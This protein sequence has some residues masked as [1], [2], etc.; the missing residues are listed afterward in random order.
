MRSRS[1][2]LRVPAV[3]LAGLLCA[4]LLQASLFAGQASDTASRVSAVLAMFP[5]TSGPARDKAAAEFL[6]LGEPGLLDACGRLSAAG[7][8]D[9]SLVRYALHGAAVY[10]ARS[11]AEAERQALSAVLVKALAAH[12]AVE[13][14]A[15]LL[16]QLQLAGRDE[17][18]PAIAA[19]L[20]DPSL[21]DPA[22]RALATIGGVAAEKALLEALAAASGEARLSAVQALGFM[23]SRAA[24]PALLAR[25]A[26]ADSVLR[27][28]ILTALAEIGDPAAQ[29]A[30]GTI[31]LAVSS[32][33]RLAAASLYLRFAERLID[34]GR[35]DEGLGILRAIASGYTGAGESQV[36][37]DALDRLTAVLGDAALPDLL[38]AAGSADPVYRA[39]ALALAEAR[40]GFDPASWMDRGG[41]FSA[42]AQADLVRLFGR[43]RD[44]EA[45]PFIKAGLESD[46]KA[47]RLAAVEAYARLRGAAAVDELLPFFA[48]DDE[49]QALVMRDAARGW[50][51]DAVLARLVPAI[52]SYPPAAQ[53]AVL[54]I[55]AERQLTASAPVILKLAVGSDE[56]VRAAALAALERT[57]GPG[58]IPA[59]L[60]L[61]QKAASPKEVVPLQ[62]ALAAACN[63]IAD[64]ERRADALLAA[65]KKAKDG[66]R[67]D[68]IRP[69]SRVGGGR[70]LLAVAAEIKGKVPASQAAALSVLSGWPDASALPELFRLAE[71]KDRKSRYLAIQGIAR[72]LGDA[73]APADRLGLWR[74]AL[75]LAVEDDEKNVLV[76]GLGALRGDEAL[77]Q[78][79]S[80]L[81]QAALQAKAAAAVVKIV[82]PA[83]GLPGLSGFD[84]GQAL[85][86]ALPY[87]ENAYDREQAEKYAWDLLLG[88]GFEAA[89]NGKNL[90]GWKGLVADPP[91]R[92]K[93]T[94]EELAKAQ[95]EA[96]ALMKA[97]WKAVDG[98][99][100]FDGRGHSLCT[101]ADY[102]DFEMFVDW[103][104]E[105]KGDSGIYLR[106]SPQVQIWDPAQWPE[107]S[108][109]LY[110]N[111]KNPKNPLVK[112]DR[113]IGEWN[114]FY[115]KMIGERVT[116]LLN[117]VLV[118]DDVLMENYWERD[119]PIYAAGQIELQSHST[120]LAF[121][122]IFIR[123]I[124]PG[125]T[126]LPAAAP[127]IGETP[128]EERAA[129][130]VSLFNGRDLSGWTGDREGYS[131]EDG[132]IAVKPDSGGNLYTEKDY[133][134]FV[135]RFEFKL[136]PGANNG[137]GIRTPPEGD[138]AYVGMEIQVLDDGAEVYKSLKPY[139]YHGSIYGVVPTRRGFQKP[140][141][142]W[143]SE[144]IRVQGRRV[145][146]RLNGVTIVDADIEKASTPQTVDGRDHPGLKR[147]SGR[148]SFCGHGSRVE[149]R[150]LRIKTLD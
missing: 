23:K 57:A 60:D 58:E 109:G 53:K 143:N 79:A 98:T 72:L 125:T 138:A 17:A 21:A 110:N 5:S 116:V 20:A 14:K 80:F 147:A 135:F 136:T 137:I 130:F 144:E 117:G 33:D 63:R 9:D 85:R 87:V 4:C 62:N 93:M 92:A 69:L 22:A 133:A 32:R 106:G 127:S 44:K 96:D 139:Q 149:F 38:E 132:V 2:I 118:V 91:A 34:N 74:K 12:P 10:A 105:S 124:I 112:A 54:E 95:S 146:V 121:K 113:P 49:D 145:T 66:K 82:L 126:G 104:I 150:N 97:H 8:E 42:A 64:R 78:A 41:A 59:L 28:A 120:P 115:I 35:R 39:K 114:T 50:P 19:C 140:V 88:A 89:F 131:V 18:V 134:D 29:P 27:P 77:K 83:I 111:Q 7:V 55:L 73:S 46:Q 94:A 86:G 123:R 45:E 90:S 26:A 56:G 75:A 128:G 122:N 6:A 129:G 141:G 70:A 51:S 52:V 25:L 24:A 1:R 16:G 37:S 99:L 148:I 68:L 3:F 71:S 108:G 15:F 13:A 47:L 119:K 67:A 100:V 102:G 36:R 30:L 84:A 11:G 61:L 48:T 142:E 65:L 103:K 101:R 43:R 31:S 76:A 107:G 40:P 81:G